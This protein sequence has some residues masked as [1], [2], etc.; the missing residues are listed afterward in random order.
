M[1][2]VHA[3][4]NR[5][6]RLILIGEAPADREIELGQPFVGASGFRL[7]QWWGVAGLKREDFYIDNLCQ[8]QA[9]HNSIDTFDRAYLEQWMGYLH[10][11]IAALPDPWLIVVLGN[12][13]LYA[14]TGKGKVKWHAKDGKGPRA[15][16]TD[17]RG[18][19]LSYTDLNGRV[20]K[21]IPT[22]H[23]AATFRQPEWE[24][25]CIRDWIK[26]AHEGTFRELNI[27]TRT[28]HIRP[29]LHDLEEFITLCE[30]NPT[31]PVAF[32][33]ENPDR[34]AVIKVVGF[35]PDPKW[36]L[37]VDMTEGYWGTENLPKAWA[38]VKRFCEG[39]VEKVLH[40][41]LS[42]SYK[43]A[44]NGI[45]LRNYKYD[46]LWEHHALDPS[47]LHSLDYCA[48]RDTRQPYWKSM[49]KDAEMGSPGTSRWEQFMIYNGLD[50]CIDRELHDVYR[51]C[52]E[53][54]GKW[55]FYLR[56]Y[57]ALLEPLH[58]LQLHGIRVDDRQ[59]RYRLANLTADCIEIQDQLETLTGVKLYGKTALSNKKLQT[60][61][62]TTLGL[63]KQERK[64]KERGEKTVSSDEVAVRRLMLKYPKVLKETGPLILTHKRKAK[65]TEFYQER[66]LDA[67]G[68]FRSSYSM[69]TEA[70]RLSS[71]KTPLDTGGN[72]QNTDRETRD[73]FLADEN[74]VGINIDGSQVEAR[75]DYLLIYQLTGD[76]SLYDK[77]MS[78]PDEYDQHTENASFIFNVP[79]DQVTKEQRYL[80]KKAV[81]GAFR[82]MQGQKLSDE[83][84]K[85]GYV[86]G[87]N[88]CQRMIQAFKAR[89][90]GIDDLFRWVRRRM[91]TD[92]YLENSWG[93]RLSF[94][95]ERVLNQYTDESYRCGYSFDPQSECADWMNQLGFV[96]FFWYLEEASKRAGK[97]VG[98]IN[99]HDHDALFFSVLPEYAYDAAL[100]LVTALEQE[101]ALRGTQF[102]VPCEVAIGR[103]RKSEYAWK[104]FPPK[105]EFQEAVR[106]LTLTL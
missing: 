11:R 3:W 15:G 62:Y 99:V 74:C 28:H 90:P 8:F 78:R 66:R 104:R 100:F 43:L 61:L 96:P 83:L 37:S 86:Y 89:V 17:W 56:H 29:S 81:H 77:A 33:V 95:K 75:V 23:P 68:R 59:R 82:D 18:S 92:G 67:D 105:E 93:R 52:L 5:K 102:R 84:L 2:Q 39:S 101:R 49:G 40:Y 41:G 30:A 31:N 94:F 19:I 35:S 64:R 7:S 46:T 26:I 1:I 10:Q 4:G 27:P 70:G 34:D 9:P 32:D 20:I 57:A 50:V 14:L 103:S 16:I 13:S 21:L 60:Y 47:D 76:R 38:L 42:D 72:G 51:Q 80:G 6:A 85:D 22:I 58:W 87:A 55:E 54:R 91:L 53:E 48:S 98:A 97:R 45:Q 73:V 71:Q 63:P 24:H 69:N 25:V 106:C 88:E 44:L 12:Y 79:T 36:S 65:L